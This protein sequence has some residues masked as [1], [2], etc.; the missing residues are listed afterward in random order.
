MVAESFPVRLLEREVN[1]EFEDPPLDQRGDKDNIPRMVCHVDCC[2]CNGASF[3]SVVVTLVMNTSIAS[4]IACVWKRYL[5]SEGATEILIN[6]LV[7]RNTTK[8]R[9]RPDKRKR[10]LSLETL[11]N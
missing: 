9:E 11:P 3:T 4:D 10:Q 7:Q 8:L 1:I 5:G 2:C 6:S